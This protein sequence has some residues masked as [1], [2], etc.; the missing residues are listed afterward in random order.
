MSYID[1]LQKVEIETIE[2]VVECV[3]CS[4]R[5]VS[6]FAEE[7]ESTGGRNVVTTALPYTNSHV[8]EDTGGVVS[9]FTLRIYIVGDNAEAI[10]GDLLEA[11]QEE[12]PAELVHMYYG[13]FQARVTTWR[14][15]HTVTELGYISGE[16]TFVPEEDPKK[17]SRTVEDAKGA[18]EEKADQSLS[19]IGAAFQAAFSMAGKAA[20][21]VNSVVDTTNAILDKI[22]TARNAMRS[23][24][25]FVLSVSQIRDNVSSILKTPGDFVNRIQ[26][27]LTMTKETFDGSDDYNGYVNES[28]IMMTS[29]DIDDGVTVTAVMNSQIQRLAL[30]SS[31]AMAVKSVV[32][33]EFENAEQ[34]HEMELL[35]NEAFEIAMTK[36]MDVDDYTS[37]ADMEAASVKYLREIKSNLAVIVEYPLND[38]ENILTVCFDCYGSLDK[39][40][41]VIARNEIAD[42]SAINRKMLKVLSK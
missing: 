20:N 3:G 27:I 7:D 35:I 14:F 11:F 32:N 30:M 1:T 23:F 34:V 8:N 29:V 15:S 24:E 12:G 17:I 37:L 21:V 28:L 31:A 36:V 41:D 16:V 22:E 38:V 6:F 18:A 13:K 5:G 9:Q 26:D 33:A 4:Y 2:G 10:R 19:K 39:V 42:P 25:K 40:E